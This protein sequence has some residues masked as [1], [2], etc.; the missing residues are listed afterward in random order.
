MSIPIYIDIN[1]Y[2]QY[3]DI[4]YYY[5]YI[6]IIFHTIIYWGM[7]HNSSGDQRVITDMAIPVAAMYLGDNTP[8]FQALWEQL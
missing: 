8:P 2:N 1:N 7:G 4:L 5:I 6:F 3:L